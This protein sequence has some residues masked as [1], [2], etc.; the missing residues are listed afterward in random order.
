MELPNDVVKL[1]FSPVNNESIAELNFCCKMCADQYQIDAV[2][3]YSSLFKFAKDRKASYK[4]ALKYVTTR[5][6]LAEAK[7]V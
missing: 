7:L 3:E 6:D 5:L 1:T 2:S 4:T